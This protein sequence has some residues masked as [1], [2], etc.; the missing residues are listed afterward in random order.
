MNR[1]RQGGE[2]GGGGAGRR[3]E[4][5]EGLGRGAMGG[6]GGGGLTRPF[7]VSRNPARGYYSRD[8]YAPGRVLFL[9]KGRREKG[10]NEKGIK[11]NER[12]R[13]KANE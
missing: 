12:E 11:A 7:G 2:V 5:G 6:R 13:K 3:G 10:E 9:G 4:R 8:H 1:W